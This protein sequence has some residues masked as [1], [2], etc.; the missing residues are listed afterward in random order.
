MDAA[1]EMQDREAAPGE[2]LNEGWVELSTGMVVFTVGD[3]I[4]TR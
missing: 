2:E 3:G 4:L 1:S